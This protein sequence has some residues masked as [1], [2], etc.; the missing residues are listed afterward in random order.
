M[1]KLDKHL[2]KALT[3]QEQRDIQLLIIDANVLTDKMAKIHTDLDI[4]AEAKTTTWNKISEIT[5]AALERY[6]NKCKHVKVRKTTYRHDARSGKNV[7][8]YH[9]ECKHC[10]K[11]FWR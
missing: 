8:G 6:R 5:S 7:A 1:I 9:Y 10:G 3:D 11:E 2:K 4:L